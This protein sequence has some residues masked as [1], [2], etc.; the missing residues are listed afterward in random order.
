MFLLIQLRHLVVCVVCYRYQHMEMGSGHVFGYGSG[1]GR[2]RYVF[3]L[4]DHGGSYLGDNGLR[5]Q[6][7]QTPV[8]AN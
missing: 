1:Y 2:Y 8:R 6:T 7:G 3:L 4:V 5:N